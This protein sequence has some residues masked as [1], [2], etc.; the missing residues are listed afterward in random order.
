VKGT[1]AKYGSNKLSV[2]MLSV[3][4]GYGTQMGE[5]MSGDFQRMRDNGVDWPNVLVPKGFDDLQRIF[6]LD[7]YGLTLIGPDGVVR[8]VNIRSE[9]VDRLMAGM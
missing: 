3:D 7:G 4:L 1:Q 8:G 9:E 6:N 2:L 5:A